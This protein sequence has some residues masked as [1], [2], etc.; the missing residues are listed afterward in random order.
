MSSMIR[1]KSLSYEHT[2]KIFFHICTF[3]KNISKL[4]F[5]VSKSAVSLYISSSV[6]STISHKTSSNSAS[7]SIS[8]SSSMLLS[9]LELNQFKGFQLYTGIS[10]TSLT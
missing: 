10:L 1:S 3:R 2:T 5:V 8:V 6:S 4:C 7:Y 9:L